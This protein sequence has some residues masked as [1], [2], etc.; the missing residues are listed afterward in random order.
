M[1]PLVRRATADDAA[2]IRAI[3]RAAY[4]KYVPR[5][6]REPAPMLADFA[7]EIVAG[8]VMVIETAGEVDGYMI[9]W[10]EADRT[11]CNRGQASSIAGREP[12]H[13]RNDDGEFVDVC[14]YRL[15]RN[16]PCD[17]EGLSQGLHALEPF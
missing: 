1:A 8:R 15:C 6:G 4:V 9:A 2:R 10:P 14:P 7:A 17:G 13:Q 3:A 12:L 11:C 16:P 5:I